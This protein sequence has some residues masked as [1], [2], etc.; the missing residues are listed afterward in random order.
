MA[1]EARRASVGA[2][3]RGRLTVRGSARGAALDQTGA[4]SH[5]ARPIA[6]RPTMLQCWKWSRRESNSHHRGADATSSLWTTAPD[7]TASARSWSR[8]SLAAMSKQCPADGRFARCLSGPG[9][10]RTVVAD[11]PCRSSPAELRALP[12]A[13]RPDRVE[14]VSAAPWNRTTISRAS[15]GCLDHVGQSGLQVLLGC[16]DERS[17]RELNPSQPVDSRSATA[18]RITEQRR[19]S[20]K[21]GRRDSN[22]LPWGHSP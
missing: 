20:R 1:A 8:T 4:A 21:G 18:S 15:A 22:P 9:R 5:G 6:L 12:S 3:G 7:S 10:I 14:G 2:M 11:M 16:C 19:T 17:V 13:A